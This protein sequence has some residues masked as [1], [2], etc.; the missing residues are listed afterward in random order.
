MIDVTVDAEGQ[1]AI[2]CESMCNTWLHRQCA[3][4]SQTLY[5]LYQGGDDPFHCP[6]AI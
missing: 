4:L 5:K 2:Y 1:K 6:H 3:G